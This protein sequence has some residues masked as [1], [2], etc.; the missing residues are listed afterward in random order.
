MT[1][2]S[3]FLLSIT[4][5]SLPTLC[6]PITTTHFKYIY[7][8]HGIP[9]GS[10]IPETTPQ[11]HLRRASQ[12]AA[13]WHVAST[14]GPRVFGSPASEC[15]QE[16]IGEFTLRNGFLVPHEKYLYGTWATGEPFIVGKNLAE[17]YYSAWKAAYAN[18]ARLDS[19]TITST[20][21]NTTM[22]WFFEDQKAFTAPN[23]F[24][25]LLLLLVGTMFA[26]F[27]G[28]LARKLV[29][30]FPRKERD[31]KG[32][33]LAVPST[34]SDGELSVL[35]GLWRTAPCPAAPLST[36]LWI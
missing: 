9:D 10:T 34:K 17:K 28:F 33:I 36:V 18:F 13:L 5:F 16:E 25:L 31:D 6:R 2:T 32:E 35:S 24:Q 22:S 14:Y 29:S 27:I 12:A 3:F 15:Q 30:R 7:R 8:H 19:V 26:V 21:S 20:E 11:F 23:L 1:T 4:K